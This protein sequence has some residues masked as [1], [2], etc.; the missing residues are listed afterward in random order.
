MISDFFKFLFLRK[1]VFCYLKQERLYSF[2][3]ELTDFLVTEERTSLLGLITISYKERSE[4]LYGNR[5][6]NLFYLF[7]RFIRYE[8]CS[9]IYGFK[10]HVSL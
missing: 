4:P 2:D 8:I 6:Q 5:M 3:K 1:R 9:R 7:D 10:F